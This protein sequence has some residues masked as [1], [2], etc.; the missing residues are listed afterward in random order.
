MP[1]SHADPS[2][3]TTVGQSIRPVGWSRSRC[4]SWYRRLRL[5]RRSDY[6]IAHGVRR[7]IRIFKSTCEPVR[8]SAR[9][10]EGMEHPGE[11][12][13]RDEQAAA[14]VEHAAKLLRQP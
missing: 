3:A 8:W 5:I 6:W 14:L 4:S 9:S 13:R 11:P 12:E 2:V 10:Y 7:L 1:D